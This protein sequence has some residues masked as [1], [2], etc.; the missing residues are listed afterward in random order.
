MHTLVEHKFRFVDYLIWLT[1]VGFIFIVSESLRTLEFVRSMHI[2]W[3]DAVSSYAFLG[4]FS[5]VVAI[6]LSLFFKGVSRLV[7]HSC[8]INIEKILQVVLFALF[9]T[10][11]MNIVRL[12]FVS[13]R[14][15]LILP[16]PFY[17]LLIYFCIGCLCFVFWS[18]YIQ[19]WMA[20][21]VQRLRP[22]V[23]GLI[24]LCGVFVSVYLLMTFLHTNP[25]SPATRIDSQK[26]L[27][28]VIIIVL[29]SLTSY[30]M[31]L[32]GYPLPTTPNL[33][34]ITKTW[35]VYVNAH[36]AGSSTIAIAPVMFTGR[37]PYTDEWYRYG[38]LIKNG[39][40]WLNLAQIL[41][42]VGYETSYFRGLG[43]APSLGIYHLEQGWDRLYDAPSSYQVLFFPGFEYISARFERIRS[44]I[45]VLF[46][47]YLPKSVNINIIPFDSESIPKIP[48]PVYDV[49]RN[50]FFEKSKKNESIPFFTFLHMRR[51]HHPYLADEITGTF[52]PFEE[53]LVTIDSQDQAIFLQKSWDESEISKLRLRYDENIRKADE[54][55][56]QLIKDLQ[57]YKLYDQSLIIITAD[58]GTCFTYGKC[59]SK[60]LG[61]IGYSTSFLEAEEENIPLLVKYPDQTE[62]V[63]IPRL[64]SNVDIMPTVLDVAGLSYPADFVDG[65]SLLNAV[66]EN[67]Q[68]VIYVRRPNEVGS[69]PKVFAALTE[70]MRFVQREDGQILEVLNKEKNIYEQVDINGG[71]DVLL[72]KRALDQ[73]EQRMLFIRSKDDVAKAPPLI[74]RI[75]H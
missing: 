15:G 21:W 62:G 4:C 17:L 10:V 20:D 64:V 44:L 75:T 36:S 14:V 56:G 3:L 12:L 60:T 25:V 30:D 11:W 41:K 58:H 13:S 19:E 28:N 7:P 66:D 65:E 74:G 29:D 6:L 42:N 33:E 34:R 53:G 49:A 1:F 5:V 47:D 54:L 73:F 48:E 43:V 22:V 55:V 51:P 8:F 67:D 50:Y 46:I 32:Y 2:Y 23:F 63:R 35:T 39:N 61:N 52:L 45:R 69:T 37:Y 72:L 18:K 57:E 59:F 71:K 27:P 68:R 31:S 9:F 24:A 40:G 16:H 38:D 26:K 70:G